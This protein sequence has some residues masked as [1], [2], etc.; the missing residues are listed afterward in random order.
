MK[1]KFSH[2][3]SHCVIDLKDFISV[4]EAI[5]KYCTTILASVV[6]ENAPHKT[7]ALHVWQTMEKMTKI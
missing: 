1:F 6:A 2:F 4:A 7:P 5:R 3:L